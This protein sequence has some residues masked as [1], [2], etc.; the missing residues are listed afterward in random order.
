MLPSDTRE[1]STRGLAAIQQSPKVADYFQSNSN[2]MA[3]FRYML[4]LLELPHPSWALR[5]L[6]GRAAQHK[7]M[8]AAY[9]ADNPH[10]ARQ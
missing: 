6:S 10:A 1:V 9:R 2:R 5:K 8:T 3:A 7:A 4:D